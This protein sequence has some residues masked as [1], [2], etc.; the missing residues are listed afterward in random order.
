MRVSDWSLRVV[1][2]AA[3]GGSR[4]AVARA[5]P[6]GHWLSG[7]EVDTI[8]RNKKNNKEI[9]IAFEHLY[10]IFI[11]ILLSEVER[12]IRISYIRTPPN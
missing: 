9:N 6:V 4:E 3:M 10:F 8:S 7:C 11:I 1:C 5:A 12:I 2:P